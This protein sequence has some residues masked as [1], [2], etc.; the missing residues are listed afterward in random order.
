MKCIL[1][2][3]LPLAMHRHVHMQLECI[4]DSPVPGDLKSIASSLLLFSSLQNTYTELEALKV[5][6]SSSQIVAR[7]A[8]IVWPGLCPSHTATLSSLS[9]ANV[10][11]VCTSVT[12]LSRANIQIT[13]G[14]SAFEAAASLVLELLFFANSKPLHRQ[15]LSWCKGFPPDKFALVM[16]RLVKL[17]T[18]AIAT[19]DVRGSDMQPI[20]IAEPLLSLL[21]SKPF[22]PPLRQDAA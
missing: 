13:H 21:E 12:A 1:S 9:N 4:T 17:V 20:T 5:C 15:I 3:V 2:C 22:Q 14:I 8:R 7:A 18:D 10:Q 19:F 16:P 11:R 6:Y